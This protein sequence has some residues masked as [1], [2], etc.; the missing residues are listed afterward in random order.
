[1][2]HHGPMR[3]ELVPRRGVT[4]G[5]DVLLGMDRAALRSE[6]TAILGEPRSHF[7]N[8]DDYISDERGTWLRLRFD[9]DRLEDVEVLRGDLYL[10][11]VPLHR[12]AR[13]SE[14]S[15]QL[16]ARGFDFS[17]ATE[18]GDCQECPQ[19][20]VNI[21]THQDVGGEGDGIEWVIV[22]AAIAGP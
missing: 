1:M 8:E 12:G 7:P 17:P 10:D 3:W 15:E 6:L 22:A 21:A 4:G 19:L 2:V 5:A 20:G 11:G 13:W 14:L 9:G 16:A 18:L